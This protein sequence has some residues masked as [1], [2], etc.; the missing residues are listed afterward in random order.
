MND[1]DKGDTVT[2]CMDVYNINIQYDERLDKLELII[3]V[4]GDLQK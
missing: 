1:P 4:I 3:V 2:P